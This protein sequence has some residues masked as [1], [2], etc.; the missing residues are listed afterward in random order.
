MPD[1]EYPHP[2]I[3]NAIENFIGIADQR[4]DADTRPLR[5]CGRRFR[6][7]SNVRNHVANSPLESRRNG[8]AESSMAIGGG[9]SEIGDGTVGKFN[10]H[11]RR[12]DANAASTS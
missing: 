7:L 8:F 2:I 10:F 9:F 12:N 6:V 5:N 11:A 3:Q 4:K 1:V